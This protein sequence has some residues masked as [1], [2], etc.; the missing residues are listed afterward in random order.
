MCKG[1]L[2]HVKPSAIEI[3]LSVLSTNRF[4][5]FSIWT[6]PAKPK[7]VETLED[8]LFNIGVANAPK[9]LKDW[10]ALGIDIDRKI[11]EHKPAITI[12]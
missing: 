4:G 3:Q 8:Y 2:S 7:K 10:M 12:T 9:T 1:H 5:G 11:S 6:D